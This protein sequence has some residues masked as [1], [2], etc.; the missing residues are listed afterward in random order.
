M[1][2]FLIFSL[3]TF[4]MASTGQLVPALFIFGDSIVDTGNNNK[5]PSLIK[6]NFLPYGR[7]FVNHQPTGRFSNGKLAIDIIA[8]LSLGFNSLPPAYLTD[9][10]H[11][12]NLLTGANFASA[13]SGYYNLTA[14]L[15]VSVIMAESE[16]THTFLLLNDVVIIYVY[17]T[18]IFIT[19]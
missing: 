15:N 1:A 4:P 6:A 8:D 5:L 17:T 12:K 7:D 10:E 19:K 16:S 11:G 3:F 14:D 18:G 2:V 9:Q 13:G